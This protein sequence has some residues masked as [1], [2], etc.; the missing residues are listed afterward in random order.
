VMY[1]AYSGFNMDLSVFL[2]CRTLNLQ[3]SLK[4]GSPSWRATEVKK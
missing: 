4:N 3:I 1:I 2:V